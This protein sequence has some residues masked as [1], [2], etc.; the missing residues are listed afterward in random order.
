M[1]T[2]RRDTLKAEKSMKRIESLTGLLL[3]EVLALR[4][5]YNNRIAA[6]KAHH[7]MKKRS[8]SALGRFVERKRGA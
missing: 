8:L 5:H 7:T 3:T 2:T 4:H 6:H 1:K